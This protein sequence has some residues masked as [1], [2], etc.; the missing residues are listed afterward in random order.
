M[1]I[2]WGSQSGTAEDQAIR[3]GQELQ[4]K[5]D[6]PVL[7][8]DLSDYEPA[9]IALV[10]KDVPVVF[11]MSTYGEGDPPDNGV[12]FTEW[13]QTDAS[14][15]LKGV[16][17]VPLGFGNSNYKFYNRVITTLDTR[18]QE[19]GG[20][21]LLPTGRIDAASEDWPEVLGQ[22][23]A[24][25]FAMLKDRFSLSECENSYVPRIQIIESAESTGNATDP[26]PKLKSRTAFELPVLKCSKIM[27]SEGKCC[28]HIELDL[29]SHHTLQYRTGD[30]LELWATNSDQ[31]VDKLL[32]VCGLAHLKSTSL[33]LSS[34]DNTL[35]LDFPSPSTA[36][37]LF[38]SHLEI[39]APLSRD[40]LT[41]L[42]QFAPTPRARELLQ[43][44][45]ENKARFTQLG[46]LSLA[47]LLLQIDETQ[48]WPIP[49][50]FL[51][52]YLPRLKP[53]YYSISSSSVQSARQLSIT[54]SIPLPKAGL[55]TGYL[56]RKHA[57]LQADA[58]LTIPANIRR[59]TFR[60][61]LANS[62]PIIL[63][64]AGTGMAPFRAFIH[65]RA[66]IHSVGK[67]SGKIMLFYGCRRE[68][69][70]LYKEE[71]LSYQRTLGADRFVIQ[72]AYSRS[73]S[74]RVYVQDR[75]RESIEQVHRLMTED[76]AA[77]YMC[78]SAAMARDIGQLISAEMMKR[79]AWDDAAWTT[80]KEQRKKLKKWQEDV[81]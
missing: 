39:S 63:I 40:F 59:S 73:G 74:Q 33:Q 19:V 27:E 62:V 57:D 69:D 20:E 75:V 3:L 22:W 48:H 56:F 12:K 14:K 77:L 41:H 9:S 58:K 61:P 44:L 21:R 8:A 5:F 38:K 34:G 10:P 29:S 55:A 68:E 50:S 6:L 31:A 47:D 16:L 76:K 30:H 42:L 46:A 28:L 51:L 18:L 36:Y 45:A 60:L 65:E 54:V 37:E 17:Y 24:S 26:S 66:A 53:R 81:W 79:N 11:V 70:F 25:F 7:V 32:Q 23:K 78:G 80:F 13:L 15:D 4:R 35:S 67:P 71:V 52:E 49:L 1:L 43:D 2:Y 64:A 72:T